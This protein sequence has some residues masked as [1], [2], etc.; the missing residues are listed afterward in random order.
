MLGAIVERFQAVLVFAVLLFFVGIISYTNLPR[1]SAPEI[2]RPLIFVNTAYPGVSAQD[3][4][5]L[6]TKPIE[7]ELDGL[8]GLDK[9]TSTSRM[10]L[11]MVVAEFTQDTEVEIALRR[12]KERVDIAK[13]EIPGDAEEPEVRELN[14]SDQPFL[15]LVLSNENGLEVLEKATEY[16]EEEIKAINGVLDVRVSGKNEKELLVELD[17]SRLKHYGF[18][19]DDVVQ[20]VQDEHITIPGGVLRNDQQNLAMA[21]T[22]EIKDVSV[23]EQLVVNARGKSA[24][25]KDIG[26]VGLVAKPK[27]TIA[28]MNGLPAITLSVTKRSGENLIHIVEE[29]KKLLEEESH[30]LPHGTQWDF[31]YDESDQIRDMVYDLENNIVTSFL[32]VVM[33]TLFF[34]GP[35]NAV[36]VSIGI[37]FSML[38]SFIV[39]SFLGITLNMVVL[40][41]LVLALGM[42]VDNGI[43]IVENIYRH[44]SEGRGRLEAAISGAKEVA[45]PIATSTLTTI[46]AFFPIIFMPGI[47]GE[48]MGYLPKTVIVV[49]ASSLFVALTITPTFCGRFLDARKEDQEKLLGD[50]GWFGKLLRQYERHL[51]LALH[52]PMST[53][54]LAF[55]VVISGI[56]LYGL[57]GKAPIFFPALDPDVATVDIELPPGASLAAT[58]AV[59]RKVQAYVPSVPA[60]LDSLQTTVGRGVGTGMSQGGLDANKANLRLGFVPFIDREI[61]AKQTILDLKGALKEF[62][63][64]KIK[65][66]EMEGGPPKGHP[67]SYEVRGEDYRVIGLLSEKIKAIISTHEDAFEDIDYDY[68]RGKPEIKVEIDRERAAHFGLGTRQISQTVRRAINGGIIGKFRQ[69]KDEYDIVVRY[70]APYRDSIADLAKLEIID[71]DTRVPLSALGRIGSEANVSV[72][73]RNDRRRAVNIW[74][75]FKPDFSDRKE[76]ERVTQDIR[77]KVAALPLPLGYQVGKGEGNKTQEESQEFLGQAFLFACAMIFLVLVIQFNSVVQP[78]IILVAVTLSLGGVFWGLLLSYQEFVIIMSGIGVISL[79]GVVVNN[80]IVL[81]DFIN[82]TYRKT[83]D[84]FTAIVEASKTRLRPVLL[85]AL[86]TVIG[87]LPM[88]FAISFDFHTFTIQMGSQSAQWFRAMAWAIIYGLTLATLL[89]LIVIPVF[90]LLGHR[91]E[92]K[93]AE[94]F[95]RLPERVKGMS[96]S[97]KS[98]K[99]GA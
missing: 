7:D 34:L 86:T 28:R 60:D 75:D 45:L 79:A 76:I 22:G 57:F 54:G 5:A 29:I 43:V 46:L 67:I 92:V 88:G 83:G 61:P 82:I 73:K 11:S 25:I 70:L 53:I 36:F 4:E 18:A 96:F 42:L 10:S 12:V 23:F 26:R 32:M 17:P 93:G 3:M 48:F 44:R 47:M 49:L 68:E 97:L 91:M 64:A 74:A 24:R 37:P 41:S 31:S 90:V 94:F 35:V 66:S 71:G 38:L 58:D 80:A 72:I 99:R 95:S 14:F 6:V 20:A 59:T 16:F 39:L 56:M 65:V 85:T 81:I 33:V 2:R 21:L 15:I 51:K 69:G 40:F 77:Q 78:L 50:D 1:E 27:E 84:M 8:E 87:L 13:T 30:K 63:D 62:T 98:G 52:Y 19:I 89:T 55:L 9:L